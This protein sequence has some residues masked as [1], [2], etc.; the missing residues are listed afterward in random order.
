MNHWTSPETNI[1]F[2]NQWLE[3]EISINFRLK[4]SF[5]G[6]HVNFLFGGGNS[7]TIIDP[8]VLWALWATQ[9]GALIKDFVSELMKSWGLLNCNEVRRVGDGDGG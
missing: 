1:S 2:E 9:L 4:W 8:L 6:G 7:S 3:D 5:F